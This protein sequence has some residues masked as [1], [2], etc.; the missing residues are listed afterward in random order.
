VAEFIPFDALP[1]KAS[2][3]IANG[4]VGGAQQAIAAGVPVIVVGVTGDEPANAARVAYDH[5]GID[6][7]SGSPAPEAVASAAE[8][9]LKDTDMNRYESQRAQARAGIRRARRGERD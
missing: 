6:L 2:V 9:V 7:Q 1:P 5:L 8:S 4:G 3:Y